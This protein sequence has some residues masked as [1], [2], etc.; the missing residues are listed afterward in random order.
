[1]DDIKKLGHWSGEH[2]V[3]SYVNDIP[4]HATLAAAGMKVKGGVCYYRLMRA[5][6]DRGPWEPLVEKIFPGIFVKLA[7][8]EEV[9]WHHHQLMIRSLHAVGL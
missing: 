6:I 9:R 8:I 5:L 3:K 7:Q 4:I 2:V 1:M